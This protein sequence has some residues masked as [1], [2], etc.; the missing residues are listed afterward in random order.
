MA[1]T[2]QIAIPITDENTGE[3]KVVFTTALVSEGTVPYQGKD[4]YL[5]KFDSGKT[6]LTEKHP[7]ESN[8]VQLMDELALEEG[9]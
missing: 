7:D 3:Q 9:M 5:I 4:M 8:I 2:T 1:N 6:Q